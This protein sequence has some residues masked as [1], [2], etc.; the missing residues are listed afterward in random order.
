VGEVGECARVLRASR[1]Q[2][3][4]VGGNA[5]DPVHGAQRAQRRPRRGR[6]ARVQHHHLAEG[7][8][9]EIMTRQITK[10]KSGRRKDV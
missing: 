5:R 7:K 2:G 9:G 1:S 10:A 8:H 3:G 4:A 6:P